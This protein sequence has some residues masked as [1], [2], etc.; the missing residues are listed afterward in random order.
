MNVLS[1]FA[2]IGGLELG[3]ERAGM[4]T[5]GQVELDPFCR[6]ILTKHWPEVP[7]HDDVRTAVTWWQTEPR[8]QVGLVAGGFPCQDLSSAHT[9][10]ARAGLAGPKSGLWSAY[11]DIVD[12][13][14]PDWV[15]VENVA[16]WRD[17]VPSVRGDLHAL[18]YASVPLRLH[19]GSFGAPHRRARVFLVANS[20]GDGE[21]LRSIHAEV[22]E[23]RPV[24]GRDRWDG[25]N[26]RPSGV[27]VADGLPARLDGARLRAL[28]NSVV[29]QVAEYVGRLI[30]AHAD[31]R[32]VGAA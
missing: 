12:A 15:V 17:W 32:Q 23:H 22:A 26:A 14:R 8:P 1:L 20:Y 16:T 25:W 29:P 28:G 13:I 27:R 30:V 6:S 31:A 18:G 4:T 3:L 5:V 24:S 21:S 11:R 7:K 19:A 2:G 10:G 9:A